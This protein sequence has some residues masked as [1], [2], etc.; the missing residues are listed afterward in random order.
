MADKATQPAVDLTADLKEL[1]HIASTADALDDLLRRGLDWLAR[2][3]PYDLATVFT[4]EGE[5][6][7]VRAARG[8]L[9][10]PRIRE[11]ELP[12]EKFP[13]IRE[14]LETRR[15]RVYTEDDHAHGDG[16]PF[17]GVLDL[18][19]GHACMVV[20][21]HAGDRSARGDDA[22]PR[23]VRAVPA[24]RSR[25]WSRSTRRCWPSPSSRASTRAAIGRVVYARER[26]RVRVLEEEL[27]AEAGG[28]L[29]ESRS[30]AVREVARRARQVA[31]DRHA[32][33]APRRDR[34]RQGAPR[35]R[36]PPWS[37]PR[38]GPFVA[39]NCAAIRRSLL[40]SRAVRAREGRLH[41]RRPRARAGRFE[42]A[43]RRHAAARRDRRAAVG[44]A[45]QAVA[46]PQESDASGRSAASRAA[47]ASTCASSPRRTSISSADR[48]RAPFA[49]ISTTG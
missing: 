48:A 6:L 15:A 23:P 31:R 24:A 7:R 5:T 43:R 44:A 29:E 49:R 18:P 16:D 12:L 33:P 10:G 14:A 19:A 22:R 35:A 1:V 36:H 13:T 46:R 25:I 17:D 37:R 2:L 27:G 41:R 40:E 9:A 34:H 39:V 8:R 32:G 3:A 26:E 38:R 20:P 30:A 42:L 4:L 45:G 11:H 47:R 21:L 28:V